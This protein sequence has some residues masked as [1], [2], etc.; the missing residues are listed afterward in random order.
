MAR[1]AFVCLLALFLGLSAVVALAAAQTFDDALWGSARTLPSRHDGLSFDTVEPF[2]VFGREAPPDAFIGLCDDTG[3]GPFDGLG[4]GMELLG[5]GVSV[6][7]LDPPYGIPKYVPLY[8]QQATL[9]VRPRPYE[10]EEATFAWQ[11]AIPPTNTPKTVYK[12]DADNEVVPGKATMT[13]TLDG[14]FATAVSEPIHIFA[15]KLTLEGLAD[16]EEQVPGGILVV[17]PIGHPRR[18]LNIAFFPEDLNAIRMDHPS[19]PFPYWVAQLK[20][21]PASAVEFF[22]EED[23][24]TPMNGEDRTWGW[25]VEQDTEP[26]GTAHYKAPPDEVWVEAVQDGPCDIALSLQFNT[27]LHREDGPTSTDIVHT[28]NIEIDLDADS[29][30]NA[31]PYGPPSRN[32][33]EESVEDV[34]ND[35]D[36]PGKVCAPNTGDADADGIP[37][38]ADGFDWDGTP[39]NADDASVGDQFIPIVLEIGWGVDLSEARVRL[40]YSDSNPAGVTYGGTPPVYA[41]PAGSGDLRIWT[42]NAGEA[43][44]A[45]SVA[46]GGHYVPSGSYDPS[47]LGFG[48][49]GPREV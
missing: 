21:D 33:Y 8:S 6:V 19:D 9:G 29:D 27:V 23:S 20:A 5:R 16:S 12:F 40:G 1:R 34:P 15:A 38:F 46:A 14:D 45:R 31:G 3:V 25:H 35:P 48:E 36:K 49:P 7:F 39:E 43:R 22:L 32:A 37:D 26:P 47:D 10:P 13:Y 11:F 2:D 4:G 18:R 17:D 42:K 30:N 28:T 41:L 24:P 44:D